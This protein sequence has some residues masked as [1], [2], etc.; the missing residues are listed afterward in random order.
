MI[1]FGISIFVTF[2]A[3]F[4]LIHD[5][6]VVRGGGNRSTWQITTALPL[7]TGNILTCPDR[8]SYASSGERQPAHIGNTIDHSAIR[9]DNSSVM[10]THVA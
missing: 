4:R 3:I 5:W 1:E 6:S 8:G 9:A 7:V 10:E 2:F